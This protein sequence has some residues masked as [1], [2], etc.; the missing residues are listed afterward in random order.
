MTGNSKVLE[1]GTTVPSWCLFVGTSMLLPAS[2]VL[3]LDELFLLSALVPPL[4]RLLSPGSKGELPLWKGLSWLNGLAS[5]GGLVGC[6]I[7][8]SGCSILKVGVILLLRLLRTTGGSN[9]VSWSPSVSEALGCFMALFRPLD[10]LF[11]TADSSTLP[12][13]AT[14]V[15]FFFFSFFS[16]SGTGG[17]GI[18]SV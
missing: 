1:E 5:K 16:V 4:L 14:R 10:V 9:L 3:L 6:C 17:G 15:L 7:G 8:S 12:A 13:V 11:G 2:V 18:N